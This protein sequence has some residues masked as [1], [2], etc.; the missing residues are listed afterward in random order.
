MNTDERRTDE[1]EEGDQENSRQ[2]GDEKDNEEPGRKTTTTLD[3]SNQ[4]RER[5][6]RAKMES[7]NP[8]RHVIE[9]AKT[10]EVAAEQQHEEEGFRM[11]EEKRRAKIQSFNPTTTNAPAIQT[12]NSVPSAVASSSMDDSNRFARKATQLHAKFAPSREQQDQPSLPLG[13]PPN[14]DYTNTT[15]DNHGQAIEMDAESTEEQRLNRV[16]DAPGFLVEANLV[17]EENSRLLVQDDTVEDGNHNVVE[18]KPAQFED[19]LQHRNMRYCMGGIG[20]CFFLFGLIVLVVLLEITTESQTE[21]I[22]RVSEDYREILNPTFPPTTFKGNATIQENNEFIIP[23]TTLTWNGYDVPLGDDPICWLSES[24]N[25]P[26]NSDLPTMQFPNPLVEDFSIAGEIEMLKRCPAGNYVSVLIP[27]EKLW[28][29]TYYDYSLLVNL[30]LDTIPGEYIETDNN[31]AT[32]ALQVVVCVSGVGLCTPWVHE[33]AN[34]REQYEEKHAGDAREGIQTTRKQV[35]GD[36]HGDT[37]VHSPWVFLD[38]GPN[39][40]VQQTVALPIIINHP[41]EY[42]VIATVQRY[43]GINGSVAYRFD[44]AGAT[45]P[46]LPRAVLYVSPPDIP[47]KYTPATIALYVTFVVIGISSLSM[48]VFLFKTVRHRE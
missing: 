47:S 45:D 44:M 38:L 27:G 42:F 9:E 35:K 6:R 24:S 2:G 10:E 12:A 43:T 31:D 32:I 26:G 21:Y 18:A 5:D 15:N 16:R 7:F 8:A 29:L 13:I 30:D 3:V 36:L 40:T 17:T 41:G 4:S 14:V 19:V 22:K 1:E 28:T 23:G 25:L 48:L 11:R 33:M 34:A 39:R 37:H 46:R 20:C